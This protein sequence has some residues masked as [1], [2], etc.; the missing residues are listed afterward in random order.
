MPKHFEYVLAAYGIWVL[1]FVVYLAY[2][3]HKARA[4]RQ[5]LARMSGRPG[6]S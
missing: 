3:R 5:A 2:L 4:A 1:T 6:D